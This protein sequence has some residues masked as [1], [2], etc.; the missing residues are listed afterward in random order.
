MSY[1]RMQ[2]S[3]R[4]LFIAVTAASVVLALGGV[5]GK[6]YRSVKARAAILIELEQ[7]AETSATCV[8]PAADH[9][10]VTIQEHDWIVTIDDA[11][12][13]WFRRIMGDHFVVSAKYGVYPTPDFVEHV[14][15][16]F[17]EANVELQESVE[18]FASAPAFDDR[19]SRREL[20]A[21][22]YSSVYRRRQPIVRLRFD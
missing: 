6:E 8:D 13:S 1:R 2:F 22:S 5:A 20:K 14:R 19:P 21:D 10:I 7:H 12:L 18:P 9:W 17:P 3:L 11:R 16:A 4:S 15:N